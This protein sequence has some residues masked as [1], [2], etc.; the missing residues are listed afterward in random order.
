[1]K[2]DLFTFFAQIV[3]FLAFVFILKVLLFDRIK[4]AMDNRTEE[5][6]SRFREADEERRKADG[7][8]NDYREKKESIEEEKNEILKEAKNKFEKK[9]DELTGRAREEVDKKKE[10][11]AK[12]VEEQES[13]FYRELQKRIGE[14]TYSL[15][16]QILSDMADA[17]LEKRM[18]GIFLDTLSSDNLEGKAIKKMKEISGEGFTV[19]SSFTVPGETKDQIKDAVKKITGKDT[20]IEFVTDE[21]IICG[22]TLVVEDIKVSWTIDGYISGLEERFHAFLE[23]KNLHQAVE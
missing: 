16:R 19:K 13:A 22:I 1:M 8:L 18:I 4:A 23:N 17:D 3:N 2:I 21:D 14:E 20:E 7:E 15:C 11:W 5:I 10:K 9:Y 6:N 12:S